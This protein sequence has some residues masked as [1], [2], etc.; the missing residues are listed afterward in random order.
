MLHRLHPGRAARERRRR[1]DAAQD[2]AKAGDSSLERLED[3]TLL[4]PPTISASVVGVVPAPL[5]YTN[6]VTPIPGSQAEET[7]AINPTNPANII[8]APMDTTAEPA[9]DVVWVSGDAGASWTAVSI[10]VPP[11]TTASDGDP[12]IGFSRSGDAVYAHLTTASDGSHFVSTAISSDD[13][14]TWTASA[15]DG[16]TG[17]SDS[18][19]F[20]AVG[21]DANNQSNDRFYLAWTRNGAVFVSSSTSGRI[22]STAV[23]VASGPKD[24]DAHAAVGPDGKLYLVWEDD[25]TAGRGKLT[26]SLSSDNGATFSAPKVIYTSKINALGGYFI[27]AQP[28]RGISMALSS[29]VDQSLGPDRGRFYVAF[30]DAPSSHDDTNIY[31]M[32]SQDGGKTFGPAVEVNDDG[33][34]NSQFLSSLAV[35]PTT[36]AVGV[37]WYDARNDVGQGGGLDPDNVPNSDVQL[38]GAVS[39]TGGASFSANFLLSSAG[40]ASNGHDAGPF[41]FGDYTGSAFFGGSFYPSWA[42]NT[43]TLFPANPDGYLGPTDVYSTRAAMVETVTANEPGGTTLYIRMA[44]SGSLGAGVTSDFVQFYES[45]S[46]SALLGVSTFTATL[47]SLDQIIVNNTDGQGVKLVIDFSDGDPIPAGGLVFNGNAIASS[48]T[49]QGTLPAALSPFLTE[50][51]TAAGP[52]AGTIQFIQ[53]VGNVLVPSTIAFSGLQ[54]VVDTVPVLGFIF[55]PPP[56]AVIVNYVGSSTPG[57]AEINS[58]DITPAFERID[59]ANKA[60]VTVDAL[61]PVAPDVHLVVDFSKGDFIPAGGAAYVG[62]PGGNNSL[63]LQGAS[64][65]GPFQSETYAAAGPGAGIVALDASVFAFSNLTLPTPAVPTPFVDVVSANSY[66]FQDPNGAITTVLDQDLVTGLTIID[67]GDTPPSFEGVEFT[68]KKILTIDGGSGDEPDSGPGD[69][70]PDTLGNVFDVLNTPAGIT[71]TINTSSAPLA[72]CNVNVEATSA[73]GPLIVNDDNDTGGALIPDTFVLGFLDHSVQRIQGM[74]TFGADA[75]DKDDLLIIDDSTD[76]ADHNNMVLSTGPVAALGTNPPPIF[77]TLTGLSPG[78][79]NY[80][81]DD[82]GTSFVTPFGVVS[83]LTIL[84]GRGANTLTIDF[85][86]GNPIPDLLF[87]GGPVASTDSNAL[88]LRGTLPTGAFVSETVTL[89]G[90]GAGTIALVERHRNDLDDQ[91]RRPEAGHGHRRGHR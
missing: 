70:D 48:L 27:P 37:S 89:T 32:S 79:I 26:F 56:A 23:K 45:Q 20:L 34:T 73:T 39:T 10:P 7:V 81:A 43:D 88:N 40:F 71:T 5:V 29:G 44:P 17:V 31:V 62:V 24:L 80:S 11:G 90:P 28:D 13:G 49:L 2:P 47:S 36:G 86:G 50:T 3:R 85:N 64:P 16:P 60:G 63:R 15:V 58:G 18:R 83:G 42:D 65:S 82:L 66:T 77:S 33:G 72:P 59:F 61:T 76:P 30:T 69:P 67:T 91:L 25:S 74:V 51:Y 19:P 68:N 21:P 57:Q 87:D 4:S 1:A 8:V 38:F 41:N 84:G 6:D 55:Q 54:P 53:Q 22:W 12:S 46:N 78:A 75:S 35:D 14:L 9:S 52:G